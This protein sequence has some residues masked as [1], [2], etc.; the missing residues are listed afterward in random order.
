MFIN[1]HNQTDYSALDSL[2]T[3]SEL[4]E[5]AKSLGQTAVAVTDH[6]TLAATWSALK[7]SQDTGVKY[8]VGCEMY[9]R[10]DL[11][12]KIDRTRHVIFLAKNQA[13]YRN[14][15]TL[16]HH[17]FEKADLDKRVY[18][19]VDWEMIEKYSEG[20]I[21]LTACG[22]GI[23]SRLLMNKETA[24]AE[25][26]LLR[27]KGI[28]GDS[29]GI[30]V[31]PN[32]M[33]SG[34]ANKK[35]DIDQQFLNRALIKL[36]EK[37]NVRVVAASNSHYLSPDESK[38]HDVLLAMGAHQPVHSSFRLR[39][40][41]PEFYPKSEE[42]VI[43]F[44]SRNYGEE[45]ARELADNSVYFADLCEAPVW[46]SPKYTNP[47][48]K[49]L[50]I[51]DMRSEADY[52][53]FVD[54]KSTTKAIGEDDVLYLRFKCEAELHRRVDLDQV[55]Y[56]ERIDHE[57]EVI[58]FQ[59][60]CSYMLIVADFLNWCR[61]EKISIGE[62]RGS[63]A[64][65]LV[66]YLIDIHRADPIKY[67]LVFARF[68]NK[69]KIAFADIDSDIAPSGREKLHTYL[70]NKYGQDCFAYVSNI[71]TITAK[72]YVKDLFR[73]LEIGGSKEASFELGNIIADSIP[74]K[75]DDGQEVK[76]FEDAYNKSPLFAEYCKKYPQLVEHKK[77]CNKLKAF[78]T[79]A[80]GV[81]ITGRPMVGLVPLRKDKEGTWAVEYDKEKVEENGLVKIDTLGLSTLD[82]VDSIIG[83]IKETASDDEIKNLENLDLHGYD[84]KA[85]ELISKGDTFGVFQ[86]GTSGGTIELCKRVKPRNMKDLA[87]I[88]SLAR[89]AAK[90]MRDP[91]IKVRDGVEKVSLM[92]P[93]LERSFGP[94]L[95]FPLFEECLMYLAQDV[96]GWS[97]AAADKLRKLTKEKGKNPK[98]ALQWRQ[99]FIDGSINNGVDQKIGAKIWDEVVVPYSQYGFNKSHAILYSLLSYKTA[100]LK[101]HFPLQFLVGTLMAEISGN[102]A[103][104]AA[105]IAKCKQELRNRKITISP[106]DINK[107]S[108][109]FRIL[110]SST[111][112]TGLD[113]IKFVSDDAIKDILDKRPFSSF[114]DFMLRVDSAKVRSNT[115]QA[116]AVSG[117]LD[118]ILNK[119]ISRQQ[120]FYYVSDYRKKLQIWQKKHDAKVETFSYAFPEEVP[121]K[122]SEIYALETMYLGEGYSC[123]P[124]QAYSLFFKEPHQ[125]FIDVKSMKDRSYCGKLAGIVKDAF[126]FKVRKEGS[127]F[128][129]QEMGKVTMEDM[130]GEQISV[131]VF[132]DKMVIFKDFIKKVHSKA[133]LGP[134]LAIKFSGSANLYDENV[135]IIFDQVFEISLPP[136]VPSDLK[137]RTISVKR[138]KAEKED[139]LDLLDSIESN[140]KFKG[141]I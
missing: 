115:I 81:I 44:F 20:L 118:S 99:E 136:K 74:P 140:L 79:H 92:H 119:K 24:K 41:V 49:E 46:V 97:L 128:F 131:T 2:I 60:M 48:G 42:Q 125:K 56:Q 137:A 90:S 59:G 64:G 111:L 61:K 98:K 5:K 130:W 141:F 120:V 25:E 126:I 8:I 23:L 86:F 38:T 129:G 13:G 6:G 19:V 15:L 11:S 27:L 66:A 51:F 45:K 73:A 43:A 65:S 35:D 37:H 76:K 124:A 103:D 69:E 94:Y 84:E 10:D 47:S 95:G 33:K 135:G 107:S 114:Q 112:L 88:T 70:A 123:K 116:L 17:A 122:V 57:L 1:L 102:K 67:D 108:L 30:E 31:Q 16:N 58:E 77:I 18:P 132:P 133:E 101:A 26:T 85:Y 55:L 121:W 106:P 138:V 50:P 72:V 28:F 80:G 34:S 71:N 21:C 127:K 117:A 12:V 53:D 109:T 87:A 4:F 52:Q 14:L 96:A 83:M 113:A 134:G 39:Y 63:V 78:S 7:A 89:P 36:G 105:N 93:L 100:V 139:K 91:Y 68:Y 110:N 104:A 75:A 32:N 40:P 82:T 29:L 3:V 54:W 9:F 22:N 62:G